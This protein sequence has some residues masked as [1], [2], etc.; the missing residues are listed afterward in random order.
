M[1]RDLKAH[2]KWSSVHIPKPLS[3]QNLHQ[4]SCWPLQQKSKQTKKT[5]QANEQL[6]PQ[7]HLFRRAPPPPGNQG[8]RKRAWRRGPQGKE[9]RKR[10]RERAHLREVCDL[11]AL[12]GILS[13][14]SKFLN[15]CIKS[16]EQK[17]MQWN[18]PVLQAK[19]QRWRTK[20]RSLYSEKNTERRSK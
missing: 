4:T 5:R 2:S 17:L 9:G 6:G 10:T 3:E 14:T 18:I 15:S 8:L 12:W 16:N 13:F 19:K 20:R 11:T 1:W 7:S